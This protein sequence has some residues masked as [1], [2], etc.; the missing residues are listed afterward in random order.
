MNYF[1]R[2]KMRKT[3]KNIVDERVVMEEMKYRS[4]AL[5]AIM[6]LLGASIITKRYIL[7]MPLDAVNTDI[8]LLILASVYP[9]VRGLF[10]GGGA[11][12]QSVAR[13]KAVTGIVAASVAVAL[14]AT[15]FNYQAFSDKYTGLLD[16]HLLAVFGIALVSMLLF[17]TV[18]YGLM[19]LSAHWTQKRIDRQLGEK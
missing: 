1:G 13:S 16:P 10:S 3:D 5:T 19:K 7:H 12:V 4:E 9:F 11:A 6:V 15:F 17:N 8:A 18:V 14:I 2:S